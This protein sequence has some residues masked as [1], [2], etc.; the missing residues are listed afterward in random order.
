MKIKFLPQGLEVEVTPEKTLLQV[1]L[2][3]QLPV[4]SICKG[5]LTCAECRVQIV[6]GESNCVPPSSAELGLIGSAWRLDS[7]RF[8]CQVRCF[9]DVTVNMAEQIQREETARKKIRG[10][11]MNVPISESKAVVDTMILS[12]KIEPAA[13]VKSRP[14][15]QQSQPSRPAVNEDDGGDDGDEVVVKV[16]SGK[17]QNR[18]GGGQGQ[19]QPKKDGSGSGNRRRRNRNRRRPDGPKPPS[20]GG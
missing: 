7:Q 14:P 15:Q 8:A 18:Q 12:E 16:S 6:E 1:A 2:E 3:N 13:E 5:K 10:A 4:R 9:G 11:K 17:P 19:Q 20:G